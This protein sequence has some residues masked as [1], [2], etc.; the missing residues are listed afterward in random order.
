MF[1]RRTVLGGLAAL[2]SSALSPLRAAPATGGI[3]TLVV[4]F[5]AGGP[6]DVAARTLAPAMSQSL[7]RKVIVEN[8]AG[9]GGVTGLNYVA[10][11]KPDGRTIGFAT[12]GAMAM[13]PHMIANM[14]FD[15]TRDIAYIGLIGKASE[16]IVASSQLP[17][18]TFAEF[19]DYARKN[20]GKVTIGSTGTGGIAHLAIELL[21][22]KAGI[23]VVHVP[24]RG[25]APAMVDVM[26]G[27][28]N[29][30]IGDVSNFIGQINS[31]RL[32]PL[33]LAG[34][35]RSPVM[36]DV[37]TAAEAGLPG[38]KVENWYAFIAAKNTPEEEQAYLN[39]ALNAA[40]KDPA[41]LRAFGDVGVVPTG[42][43]PS[44]LRDFEQAEY[45]RWGA[46]IRSAGIKA[47]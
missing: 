10:Q 12:V 19:L 22:S 47:E 6:A 9:V 28:V 21:K 25:A 23:D 26:A 32:R 34:D 17:V 44:A 14:P 16:L 7:Q 1:T 3:Q 11:S 46:L 41:V 39:A 36:P 38:Y 13:A 15:P 33:A 31:D 8:R 2:G 30:M 20:P 4:P 27:Q 29:A 45:A 24:Y 5:A 35:V 42:G 18:K 37:P 40:L 43:P